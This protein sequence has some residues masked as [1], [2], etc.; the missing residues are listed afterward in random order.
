MSRCNDLH[1][2]P[3]NFLPL[4]DR[5]C[6]ACVALFLSWTFM[7]LFSLPRMF[8][9][10][11]GNTFD[12]S[13]DNMTMLMSF[14]HRRKARHSSQVNP[15]SICVRACTYEIASSLNIVHQHR[16][17]IFFCS[18]VLSHFPFPVSQ[19]QFPSLSL[20]H[21]FKMSNGPTNRIESETA[22]A[23]FQPTLVP[24]DGDEHVFSLVRRGICKN[25]QLSVSASCGLRERVVQRRFWDSVR[26]EATKDGPDA[27][28]SYLRDH[29]HQLPNPK[30]ASAAATPESQRPVF[31]RKTASASKLNQVIVVTPSRKDVVVVDTR[32]STSRTV[33]V[34]SMARNRGSNSLATM[35]VGNDDTRDESVIEASTQSTKRRRHQ[36]FLVKRAAVPCA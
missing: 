32:P 23:G 19:A 12:L 18:L 34:F 21:S 27:L 31:R 35:R 14:I 10:L 5:A 25:T 9:S 33:Q 20:K 3:L 28:L 17:L 15:P 11:P 7:L 4:N 2:I 1:A 6:C 29:I 26:E 13:A 36:P 22:T 8:L 16:S 30:Q 24:K